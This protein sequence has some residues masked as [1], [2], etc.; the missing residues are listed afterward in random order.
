[1][2]SGNTHRHCEASKEW[3]ENLGVGKPYDDQI[4]SRLEDYL[5]AKVYDGQGQKEK[6]QVCFNRV[7]AVKT[8]PKYFE[9]ARLLTALALREVGK[10]TEADA[11]VTSWAKDFP[12]SKPA[13]WCAAIYN[14]DKSRYSQQDTTPWEATY[15]DTNFDLIVRLF[16]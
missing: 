13:Q 10:Q 1:M 14:G 5:E 16:K 2:V 3:P 4:D 15:R 11:M 6:A 12:D 8:S 7:A 9:S